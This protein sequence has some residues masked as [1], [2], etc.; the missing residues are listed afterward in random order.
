MKNYNNDMP[1]YKAAKRI[2]CLNAQL[3]RQ[4]EL[5]SQKFDLDGIEW[6]SAELVSGLT[7]RDGLLYSEGHLVAEWAHECYVNQN[8]GFFEDDCYGWLY[9]RTD[10]PVRF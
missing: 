10:V 8:Q 7:A 9:F 5:L 1:I 2:A 3:A 6:N 4:V